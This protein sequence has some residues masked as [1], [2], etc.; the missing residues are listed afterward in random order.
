MQKNGF[1]LIEL[2]MV[3]A[4]MGVLATV[5]LFSYQDY[6]K[7]AHVSEGIYISGNTKFAIYEYFYKHGTW[8]STNTTA[9]LPLAASITGR[10]TRSVAVNNGNII[11]T[12]NTYVGSG[13]TIILAPTLDSNG[14]IVWRCNTG[15]TVLTKY[16]PQNCR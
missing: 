2:M 3:V 9:D 7:R 14:S 5:A 10:G 8:P 16:R 11:I 13:Q 6:L 4:I 15:G 12:F 1:T